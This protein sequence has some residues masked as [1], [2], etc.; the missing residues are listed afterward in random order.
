MAENKD[1]I[2]AKIQAIS[3]D[4]YRSITRPP[5]KDPRKA[6]AW[7]DTITIPNKVDR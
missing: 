6:P 3:N 5:T 2:I 1:I 7:W 4:P